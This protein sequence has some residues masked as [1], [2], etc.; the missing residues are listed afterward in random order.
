MLRNEVILILKELLKDNKKRKLHL[1]LNTRRFYNGLLINYDDEKSLS[2][3]DNKL[4]YIPV[5]YSQI[6][7]IEPMIER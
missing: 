7:N 5:L 3:I 4:G 1:T 2:F 6:V